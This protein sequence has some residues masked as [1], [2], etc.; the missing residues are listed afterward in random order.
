MKQI[1]SYDWTSRGMDKS[2]Y[3][4]VYVECENEAEFQRIYNGMKQRAE[5]LK[6][7]FEKATGGK[8]SEWYEET[9]PEEWALECFSF[10]DIQNVKASYQYQHGMGWYGQ[11]FNAVGFSIKEGPR[12]D[13]TEIYYLKPGSITGHKRYKE[14]SNEWMLHCNS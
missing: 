11:E 2:R 10:R 3:S 14:S 7:A 8:F 12:W 4:C 5:R 1:Y 9:T 6:E 13:Y